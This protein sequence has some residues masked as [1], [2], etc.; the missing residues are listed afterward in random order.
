MKVKIFVDRLFSV[1]PVFFSCHLIFLDPTVATKE[2]IKT[3]T[4]IVVTSTEPANHDLTVTTTKK[5][6][7]LL[8]CKTVSV[9]LKS[10]AL[11]NKITGIYHGI[12]MESE[13]INGKSS[14]K[15]N[16]N[17]IW[18]LPNENNWLIGPSNWI[19]EDA[20][21][22]HASNTFEG[23]TDYRNQWKYWGGSSW[24]LSSDSEDVTVTCKDKIPDGT[25]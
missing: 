20:A 10:S 18:Y 3:T 8:P 17:A 21:Y 6:T 25:F 2:P 14:W 12:Y 11:T 13:V 4:E 7:S 16:D 24:K 19:G 9:M 23:L 15:Y 1:Y 22:I 5:P